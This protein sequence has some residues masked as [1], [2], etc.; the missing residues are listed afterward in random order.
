MYDVAALGELLVDC[1]CADGDSGGYPT[2][3]VHPGGAPANYLAAL[4]ALGAKTALIGKVGDD[5]FGHLLVKTLEECGISAQGVAVDASVFTTMAFVTLDACGERT[6][7]FARKPGADTCLRWDEVPRQLIDGAKVFHFGSLSLTDEPARSATQQAVAYAKKQGKR[8][9]FD[10]NLRPPLWRNLDE[11][12]QQ[13]LWGLGKADVVKISDD[14]VAFLFDRAPQ[15]GA[16]YIVEQFGAKL[17]FVTCGAAGCVYD[18]GR[19]QG[20]VKPCVTVETVDTT[21]AGDIFGGSAMWKLLQTGKEPEELSEQEL[22]DIAAFACAAA[23]L[24]TARY[25]GIGSAPCYEEVMAA[26]AR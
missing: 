23:T 12:R 8:I 20:A 21:G 18:N 11:A 6:F 7:S 10:P 25:G 17:V 14:E 3:A 5:A 9:S 16:R 15:A 19:V 13:M 2:L 24:S 26:M 22:E 1:I 4:A